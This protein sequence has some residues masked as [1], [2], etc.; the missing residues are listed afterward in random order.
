SIYRRVIGLGI[1][2]DPRAKEIFDRMLITE[3]EIIA[4]QIEQ[5]RTPIQVDIDGLPEGV[6]KRIER[7]QT[8]AHDEAISILLK[9][10][11]HEI[12]EDRQ[13]FLEERRKALQEQIED[14]LSKDPVYVVQAELK[15]KL[16]SSKSGKALS[17]DYID[18][19]M[20]QERRELFD[21]VS[22]LNGYSSGDHLAKTILEAPSF[23]E[24]VQS[25]LKSE[26]AVYAD[27]KDTALLKEE[28]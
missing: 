25:E 9:R 7:L 2:V 26:M 3:D 8:K 23:S 15:K 24:A 12:K 5:A 21:L 18:Q 14:R 13:L 16:K 27:L 19:R 11:L 10:Q 17:R 28:A 20:T 4:A 1:E 22:D 6:V